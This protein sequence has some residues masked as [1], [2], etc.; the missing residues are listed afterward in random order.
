[1]RG[2]RARCLDRCN[3]LHQSL[4]T[5]PQ[6]TAGQ[7]PTATRPDRRS[8]GKPQTRTLAPSLTA[9]AARLAPGA[10]SSRRLAPATPLTR[11]AGRSPR[12]RVVTPARVRWTTRK[13]R[14]VAPAGPLPQSEI[15]LARVIRQYPLI[16]ANTSSTSS[17]DEDPGVTERL[18]Q[19][20]RRAKRRKTVHGSAASEVNEL[21]WTYLEYRAVGTSGR[22]MYVRS[23]AKLAPFV[24]L[25]DLRKLPADTLDGKLAAYFNHLFFAGEAPA[26]GEKCMAAVMDYVPR[27]GKVGSERLPRSW[28]CLRGWRRLV[29]SRSRKPLPWSVWTAVCWRLVERGLSEMGLFVLLSVSLY[30]RPGELLAARRMDLVPP[31]SRALDYW[32]LLVAP[33]EMLQPT[34]ANVFNDSIALDD[35]KIRFLEPILRDMASAHDTSCLWNFTYPQFAREF[36]EVVAELHLPSVVPYQM[37][38]SGP[39][40]DLADKTRSTE[41]A[42][43]R[44][45]W[46]SARS[47]QRYERHA[48]L[49]AEWAKLTNA[50]RRLFGLCEDHIADIM[51]QRPHP[52]RLALIA[53]GRRASTPL[54]SSQA[55]TRSRAASPRKG[56]SRDAGTSKTGQKGT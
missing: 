1:M 27:Y 47:M 26:N 10:E 16:P 15:E 48:R 19:T 45:R 49:S 5:G 33:E 24:S 52:A 39:S 31:S 37:R 38:H 44:G 17:S 32:A 21:G 7:L 9:P 22:A 51:Y 14:K 53:S 36:K 30:T 40:I 43:K 50:Q 8:P 56:P 4:R 35:A 23:L 6:R 25:D 11:A 12:T 54:N 3:A 41:Q 28:R 46:A 29:P 18:K 2:S 20:K 13:T 42:Q 34:K 55:T